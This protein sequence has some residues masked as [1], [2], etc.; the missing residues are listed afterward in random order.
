MPTAAQRVHYRERQILQAA[1]LSDEQNYLTATRRRHNIGGH[2]WGIVH[3][4]DLKVD[5]NGARVEPGMAVDGFGRELIV[6]ALV[7]L[8][9]SAFDKLQTNAIDVWLL[10]GRTAETPPQ[11]GRWDCGPGKESRWSEGAWLR[12]EPAPSAPVDPRQPPGVSDTDLDFGPQ[13][14]PPDD[15]TREWPVYLGRLERDSSAAVAVVRPYA[16]LVGSLVQ[17][18]AGS[19]HVQV[20]ALRAGDRR[21]FAISVADSSGTLK[22]RLVIDAAGDTTIESDAALL[23]GTITI[24][25]PSNLKGPLPGGVT[26]L[27]RSE[28]PKQASP[29]KVYRTLVPGNKPRTDEL[30]VEIAKPAD[31]TDPQRFRLTVGHTDGGTFTPCLQVEADCTVRVKGNLK[32]ECQLIEAPIAA[33]ADDP[34]FGAA[35]VD[36]WAKGLA[37]AGTQ[38]GG[39]FSPTLGVKITAPTLVDPGTTLKY[40]VNLTNSSGGAVTNLDVRDNV[41]VGTVVVQRDR[42]GAGQLPATLA[43]GASTEVEATCRVPDNTSGQQ[44]N[45]AVLGIAVSA[46]GTL[47][48]GTQSTTVKI[49][50]LIQ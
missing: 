45:I 12:L 34:R 5:E 36:Q 27:P 39:V 29:W 7:P 21:R 49:E 26:F 4:L 8:D 47:V 46:S 9:G 15:P 50:D 18:P 41:V 32:V 23:D 48:Y 31:P 42:I 37:A 30:R 43:P 33:D 24:V 10:Y 11:H 3:G 17:D 20:G 25:A 19:A 35:L 1:D 22:E 6:P 44:L 40:S 38:L 13:D 2:G 14:L 16:A 28:P